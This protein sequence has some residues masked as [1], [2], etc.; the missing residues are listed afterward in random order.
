MSY[1]GKITVPDIPT[2]CTLWRSTVHRYLSARWLPTGR[3]QLASQS[4]P[5]SA[6]LGAWLVRTL[7]PLPLQGNLQVSPDHCLLG[8]A[9]TW[10]WV[11]ISPFFDQRINL[12]FAS[13]IN[14][15]SFYWLIGHLTEEHLL[16]TWSWRDISEWWLEVRLQF[17][18]QK[19]N[20]GSQ[21]ENQES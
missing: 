17:S 7:P 1:P 16:G 4:G 21:V 18:A 11:C 10:T 20:L 9:C 19:L 15:F 5:K 2:Q 13:K 14:L 6:A 3:V 8:I 12:P